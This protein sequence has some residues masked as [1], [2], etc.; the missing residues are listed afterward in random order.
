MSG[1]EQLEARLRQLELFKDASDVIHATLDFNVLVRGTITMLRDAFNTEAASISFVSEN[2]DNLNFYTAVG[3]SKDKVVES[4]IPKGKGIAWWV[5][6]N[7]QL[8]KVN[9]VT[10]DPRFYNRIDGD[11]GFTTHSMIAAP[12]IVDDKPVGVIEILNHRDNKLFDNDD[13]DMLASIAEMVGTSLA[14][15]RAIQRLTDAKNE[16]NYIVNSLTEIMIVVDNNI[17]IK[18]I[19]KAFENNTLFTRNEVIG[20]ELEYVFSEESVTEGVKTAK[21][22]AR[23]KNIYNRKCS[24]KNKIS[25]EFHINL[26]AFPL[27]NTEDKIIGALLLA[28]DIEEVVRLSEELLKS[29]GTSD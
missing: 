29:T 13:L 10:K 12:V 18:E 11:S 25:H 15:V 17:K 19:N 26:N 1:V 28:R 22:A 3:K 16:I 21:R 27:R 6:E 8:A 20:K 2:G 14:H 7:R 5:I 24:L 4:S 23:G 9:D